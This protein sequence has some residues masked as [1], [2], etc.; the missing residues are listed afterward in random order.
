ML[1]QHILSVLHQDRL[2]YLKG[3]VATAKHNSYKDSTPSTESKENYTTAYTQQTNKE[4][5][6]TYSTQKAQ[7]VTNGESTS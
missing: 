5:S 3:Y 6:T 7:Q 1:H 2:Q 4:C